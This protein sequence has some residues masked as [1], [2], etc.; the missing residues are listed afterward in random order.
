MISKFEEIPWAFDGDIARANSGSMK[1]SRK[2]HKEF[3]VK[4]FKLAGP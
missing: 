2:R 4:E 1:A 3:T